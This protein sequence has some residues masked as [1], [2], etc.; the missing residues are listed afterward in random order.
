MLLN[1]VIFCFWKTP[2]AYAKLCIL[3]SGLTV[4]NMQS[5]YIL[6]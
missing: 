1:L 4:T 2:Q 3:R 5:K 6:V